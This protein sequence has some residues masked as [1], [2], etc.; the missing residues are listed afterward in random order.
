MKP[1]AYDPQDGYRYQILCRNPQYGREWEHC[2]YATDRSDRAHL[3]AN[4]RQ[5]YGAGWEFR[6]FELPRRCWATLGL[7][8]KKT[9]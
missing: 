2:D 8:S 6:T 4:Y 3:L 5:A 1:K 9:A 7:G